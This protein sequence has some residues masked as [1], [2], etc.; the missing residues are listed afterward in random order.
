MKT[1]CLS[2][3]IAAFG[4]LLLSFTAPAALAAQTQVLHSN[5][6]AIVKSLQPLGRFPGTNRLSLAIGL[7]LRNQAALSNLLQQIYDPASPNY[8]HYLTPEQ[9]TERFGPT[10]A[11][12]Q[13]VI[14]FA[15]A[16][17]LRV[18]TTHPNRVLLDVSGS[19][20]D[21]E[22]ALHVTMQTF[23]HPTENR[24][25]YAPDTEPSLDLAMPVLHISGLDN[26]SLPRP[27]L[28]ANAAGRRAERIAEFRLRARAATYMGNDFRAA[29]VPDTTLDRFGTNGRAA[30]I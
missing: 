12:Y 13:A 29:Y 17:G 24:T 14:A 11:D 6:P 22:R 15:K 30:A 20:T 28:V 21:V 1:K 18:T 5:V 9:F 27:R 23:R 7:P 8:H 25:F 2:G 4:G 16:N 3:A 19:V 26:Y 10:E